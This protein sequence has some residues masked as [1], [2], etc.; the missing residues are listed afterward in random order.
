MEVVLAGLWLA[1]R[2]GRDTLLNAM[3]PAVVRLASTP[4][5]T[6]PPSASVTSTDS[7]AAVL[8]DHSRPKAKTYSLSSTEE[9]SGTDPTA[10]TSSC[11]AIGTTS[12]CAAR[13]SLPP[14]SSNFTR[15]FK[16]RS[17]VSMSTL[18]ANRSQTGPKI[19]WQT[20][21]AVAMASGAHKRTREYRFP[22]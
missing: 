15:R 9:R 10:M 19:E 3:S 21:L 5:Q 8:I 22:L 7:F 18:E 12:L 17:K 11:V 1:A 13:C 20:H 6:G 2:R 14:R 16:S 4:R